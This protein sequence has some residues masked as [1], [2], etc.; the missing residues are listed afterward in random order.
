LW[1]K[2]AFSTPGHWIGTA[3]LIGKILLQIVPIG[4][5]FFTCILNIYNCFF[6]YKKIRLTARQ[7]VKKGRDLYEQCDQEESH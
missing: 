3:L 1:A 2:S 4:K 6:M 7:T 5:Y